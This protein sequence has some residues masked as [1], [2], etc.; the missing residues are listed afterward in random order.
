MAKKHTYALTV[1]WTGDQGS[2]TSRYDAYSRDHL[3][4]VPNKAAIEA[5]SDPAFRG[6]AARHNPEELFVASLSS[7]HMLWYLHLC[8]TNGVVVTGYVDE[9]LG[10]MEEERARRRPLH[11]RPAAPARDD[12]RGRRC[13]TGDAA[14]RRCAPLLFH[15]ELGEFPGAL[16][17]VDRHFDALASLTPPSADC[18]ASGFDT[19]DV[20]PAS[21]A[22]MFLNAALKYSS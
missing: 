18:S 6:D 21:N 4:R 2:G 20:S 14:A 11:R 19:L 17:A 8:A 16:R 9:A 13:R 1:V 12:R 10:T 5:S 7:C 3:V 22:R 15:R